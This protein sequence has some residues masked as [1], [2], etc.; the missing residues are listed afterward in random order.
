MNSHFEQL[1]LEASGASAIQHHQQ[2]QQLWSGYG[3][4]LR[5]DLDGADVASVI[6]K[7]ISIPDEIAHPRGWNTSRSHARK[8]RSYEV[9]MAW[10]Q[11]WQPYF[12]SG[13][14]EHCRIAHCYG[15]SSHGHEHAI[16][17]E[18]LDAAGFHLRYSDL[19]FEQLKPCLD[20]LAHFHAR[21]M[22][23]EP[24]RLWPKGSYWHLAT[25]LDE[26]AAMNNRPL[27]Q[28]A[29]AIDQALSSSPHQTII[30]GDAKVANFCFTDDGQVAAVDFQYVGGGCGI[31]DL[32]Y[33]LGSCLSEA[34][35]EAWQNRILDHYFAQFQQGLSHYHPHL[36]ASAIEQD[37]R[38]LY[39]YAWADFHRFLDGWSPTHHKLTG[40]SRRMVEQALDDLKLGQKST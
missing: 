3:E 39:P 33:L 14:D 31:K 26:L 1:V 13:H 21:F 7:Y 9:E 10:Y 30:H 16:V 8:L 37:W 28:A 38:S 34:Q 35:C 27:K 18:D 24:H 36:D 17:L 29:A 5:L 32:A 12:K 40:Y 11:H 6:L 4:I 19:N 23:V 20:W 22:Q 15:I 25:R 2:L